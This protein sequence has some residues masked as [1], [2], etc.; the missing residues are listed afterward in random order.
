MAEIS[1]EA[2]NLISEHL[3]VEGKIYFL[4]EIANSSPY[5]ITIPERL[6]VIGMIHEQRA[7]LR[8]NT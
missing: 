3:T 5:E 7:I 1:L 8:N 4:E 6:A 2:Y